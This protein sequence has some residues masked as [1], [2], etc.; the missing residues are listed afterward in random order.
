MKEFRE[1]C[2]GGPK[3]FQSFDIAARAAEFGMTGIVALRTGKTIERDSANMKAKGCPEA[4]QFIHLPAR[5][6]WLA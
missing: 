5:K 4:D 6:K 3:T 1:A 2:R